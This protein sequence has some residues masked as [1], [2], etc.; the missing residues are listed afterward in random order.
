MQ[1]KNLL[2][3]TDQIARVADMLHLI[4]DIFGQIRLDEL[5]LSDKSMSAICQI[6]D[7]LSRKTDS[8]I[9]MLMVEE[10]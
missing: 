10:L 2:D 1:N 5:M 4:T 3:A 9:E 8:I 6:F 7:D